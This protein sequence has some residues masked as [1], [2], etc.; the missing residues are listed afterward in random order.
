MEATWLTSAGTGQQLTLLL[1]LIKNTNIC[2]CAL[3][4]K[5][6]GLWLVAAICRTFLLLYFCFTTEQSSYTLHQF[7]CLSFSLLV[8][9]RHPKLWWGLQSTQ[10]RWI[11]QLQHQSLPA[12]PQQRG[13]ICSHQQLSPLPAHQNQKQSKV[14]FSLCV[15]LP[16]GCDIKMKTQLVNKFSLFVCTQLYSELHFLVLSDYTSI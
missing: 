16:W 8:S 14:R 10:Q 2:P 12:L 5:P 9:W 13:G 6:A 7:F 1:F 3:P 4:K 15:C 11:A